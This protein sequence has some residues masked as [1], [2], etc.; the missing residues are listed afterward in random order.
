M[1]ITAMLEISF[2]DEMKMVAGL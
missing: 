2:R 1:S